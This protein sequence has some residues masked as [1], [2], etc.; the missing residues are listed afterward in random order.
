MN[1]FKMKT[2]DKRK[3]LKTK[4]KNMIE[5][6]KNELHKKTFEMFKYNTKIIY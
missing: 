1:S 3:E 5:H 6:K 2:D 4:L